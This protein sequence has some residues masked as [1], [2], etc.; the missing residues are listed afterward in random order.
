MT[1]PI[2]PG[3]LAE[4][5]DRPFVAVLALCLA[6]LVGS[7]LGPRSGYEQASATADETEEH[8]EAVERLRDQ[9]G[10]TLAPLRGLLENP[11]DSPGSNHETFQ[12]FE[13]ELANLA[14]ASER[15]HESHERMNA[16]AQ[17]FFGDWSAD[18]ARIVDADL[19]QSAG[20]RRETLQ[21]NY[22]RL[23]RGE[24]AAD[25][26]VE[27]F[28]AHLEDLRVYLEHDLTAAGL[29]AARGTIAK[30]FDEGSKLE[31]QLTELVRQTDE[32]KKSLASLQAMTP[33]TARAGR[34]PRVQ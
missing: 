25:A 28:A 5:M 22:D 2:D 4:P 21:A 29:S 14:L 17:R 34:A 23:A 6:G 26:S 27:R 9:V 10:L 30:A 13:R 33:A 32:A 20:E 3:S 7:C 16:S 18:S 24:A 12:T 31:A 15:S 11:S 1:V 19:K 8:R